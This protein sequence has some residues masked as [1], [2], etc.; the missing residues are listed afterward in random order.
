MKL[1]F[2]VEK[3]EEA[4]LI[5]GIGEEF[6]HKIAILQNAEELLSLSFIPD[7]VIVESKIISDEN[8]L[9]IIFSSSER[10]LF[11]LPFWEKAG[12]KLEKLREKAEKFGFRKRKVK[13]IKRPF[14]AEELIKY[15]EAIFFAKGSKE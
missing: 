9:K 1:A 10:I 2:V 13:V 15:I 12:E 4:R 6:G 5:K 11:I 8:E 7:V 3:L 14:T